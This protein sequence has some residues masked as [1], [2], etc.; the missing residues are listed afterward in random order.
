MPPPGAAAVSMAVGTPAHTF[1]PPTPA[2]GAFNMMSPC[3]VCRQRTPACDRG[4]AMARA[5]AATP[6][7]LEVRQNSSATI[8]R[9][10][11]AGEYACRRDR[12]RRSEKVVWCAQ[13]RRHQQRRVAVACRRAGRRAAQR[14]AAQPQRGG[15]R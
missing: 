6:P 8:E 10:P 4:R 12:R 13:R 15:C 3:P 5:A 11:G 2:E 1:R 7:R 9:P 14:A